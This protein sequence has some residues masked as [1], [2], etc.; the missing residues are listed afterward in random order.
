MESLTGLASA[1]SPA[2]VKSM[3]TSLRRLKIQD[4]SSAVAAPEAPPPLF[5]IDG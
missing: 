5:S 1:S 4:V 3:V 2:L